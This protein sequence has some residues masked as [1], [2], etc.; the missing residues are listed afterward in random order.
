[1]TSTEIIEAIKV[2]SDI[3]SN[4]GFYSKNILEK[5][6]NKLAELISNINK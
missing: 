4:P 1:M 5:A 6:E 2:L 3:V